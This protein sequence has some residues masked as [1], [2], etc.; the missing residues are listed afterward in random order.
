MATLSILYATAEAAP[1]VK[2]G[3]LADVA[4]ALPPALTELGLQCDLALPLYRTIRKQGREIEPVENVS[5]FELYGAK[6][7]FYRMRIA[8][9][10]TDC[11]LIDTDDGLYDV[12]HPYTDE[13]G[14]A[15]P[16]T[17]ER[18][19]FFQRA[20]LH[21]LVHLKSSGR[22][23]Y[24][25]IHANDHQTALLPT[26]LR[27]TSYGTALGQPRSVLTIH[28]LGYQGIYPEEPG[29]YFTPAEVERHTGL[30]A[31]LYYP[32]G[33]LEYYG[34]LNCLK[35][36]LLAADAIT[37]VS[38]TY[39]REITEHPEMAFGLY[40]VLRAV[41]PK[42]VGLLNGIDTTVWNPRSDEH[43]SALG[44]ATYSVSQMAGK[45]ACKRALFQTVGFPPS[46]LARPLL[47]CI[48]RL[49]PQKGADLLAKAL[50]SLV[51]QDAYVVILGSGPE[52][53]KLEEA[54]K[55]WKGRV[56]LELGYNEP[57]SHLI[58]A[59][60]DFILMPSLYEPCGLNQLYG[61]AYGTP[62]IVRRTGGLA[63]TVRDATAEPETGTGYSFGPYD[64]DAFLGA[65]TRALLA[66]GSRDYRKLRY[67]AMSVDHDWT[68][69]AEPYRDL[70]RALN[71][72]EALPSPRRDG[73][74]SAEEL[75]G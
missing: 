58:T 52:R 32:T 15:L 28:N 2:V 67:R 20:L 74:G 27:E 11:W 24:D 25:I 21:L 68:K 14:K 65:C 17:M 16:R 5:P 6:A 57:L 69:A 9:T 62:P 41:R 22:A 42:L 43:L 44:G 38:P 35:A 36:G 29:R 40:D 75:V 1:L 47:G 31:R 70:Y 71:R 59:G 55:P 10:G 64:A 12:P 37:T 60:S 50:P 19:L 3:G 23:R 48:T 53:A 46:R 73:N 4:M 26:Y 56:K 34:H 7:D 8:E 54:A 39:A 66:Y 30:P 61:L 72:G 45:I 63:D 49:V 51:A 18:F 33:P 13:A